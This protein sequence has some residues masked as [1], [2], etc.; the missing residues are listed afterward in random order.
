M[1]DLIKQRLLGMLIVVIVGVV[2]IPD[3]LDGKKETTKADFKKIPDKPMFDQEANNEEFPVA[4]VEE[5]I[6]KVPQEADEKAIDDEVTEVENVEVQSLAEQ[7]NL[8][9]SQPE[10]VLENSA[11][12]TIAKSEETSSQPQEAQVSVT[13]SDFKKP[14]WILQLGSFK[15]KENVVTLREKLREAGIETY[16]KPVQT[17]AGILSKVYVGPEQDKEVLEKTQIKIKEIN[18]LVGKI[19]RFETRN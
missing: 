2:F 16:T 14:M 15:H 1:T 10:V 12:A 5:T 17:K 6:S 9:E 18:G 3:L 11:S 19:T 8:D 13:K 7:N 4:L